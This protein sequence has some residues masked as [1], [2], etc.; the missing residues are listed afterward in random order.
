[1]RADGLITFFSCASIVLGGC[2]LGPTPETPVLSTPE[3]YSAPLELGIGKAAQT[4]RW[5][6]GFED[7]LLNELI[8]SA[9]SENLDLRIAKAQLREARTVQRAARSDLL[10]SLDAFV[11]TALATTFEDDDITADTANSSGFLFFF[12]PDIF[13]RNRRSAE[14]AQARLRAAALNADD[15]ARLTAQTVA[16][17]YIELR[18][19]GARLSLLETALDLQQQTLRIVDSRYRAGL[20]P[21]LDVDRSAADLARTNAQRGNLIESQQTANFALAVLRAQAPKQLQSTPNQSGVPRLAL[22][23]S[24]GVPADLLRRRPDVRFAEAGLLAAIAEIGVETADLY[25]RLTL[26]GVLRADLG[27]SGSISDTIVANLSAMLDLPLFDGGRRR[28]EIRGAEA[29]ADAALLNYK[30]TL[31]TGLFEVES[32]LARVRN[33]QFRLTQIEESVNYSRSAFDQLNALYREGL[34]SFIDVLDVQRTLISS[35]EDQVDTQ[36]EIATTLVT[37]YSALGLSATNES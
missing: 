35:R 29:R 12:N 34:A 1:M 9:L 32:A 33:L 20:S 16:Q 27:A 13:G 17:R 26:P 2:A 24:I 11:D 37:L 28:A 19:A 4:D 36:A 10:P 21:K 30:K 15:V 8:A 22:S 3:F 18:R 14:A 23:S 25:P 6:L 7:E 31:L 5:W